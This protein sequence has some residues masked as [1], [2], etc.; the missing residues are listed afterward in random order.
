MNQKKILIISEYFYPEEFKINELVWAWKEKGYHVDVI[1]T[2]PTYPQGEVFRTYTNRWFQ[3]ES[4]KGITIYRV[5][6]V[7]GYKQNLFKKILK[8]ISFMLLGSLVS[9][10][11]GKKYDYVF[12]YD[13]GALTGMI[14][15]I[16]LK[17]FYNIPVTLWI[18]DIWPDSV[19]AYGFKK[20]TPLNFILNSFVKFVY[21]YT[22]NFAVS[23]Q[24][25]KQ[26]IVP[27]LDS[28]KPILYAP[29]WTDPLNNSTEDFIFTDDNKIHFTFAG[30]VGKVQ[31]LENI[32]LAFATLE[33]IFI[34]KAQ[35]NII[36][37]GS[38]LT[39]LKELVRKNNIKSV[40]FHGKKPRNEISKYL[41]ASHFL[42]VSLNDDP[43]FSLTVPSKV[44]TYIAVKKPIIGIINGETASLVTKYELGYIAHPNNLQEI[45]SILVKALTTQHITIDQFTKNCELLTNTLF[46]KNT[47]INSLL[48]LTLTRTD[49]LSLE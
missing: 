7:T 30:N 46:E 28:S 5:K 35:F 13:V 26:R 37:D 32:I 42:I 16:L 15:A 47:I 45:T 41:S 19:Y 31:N 22:S 9:L 21:K 34:S 27:Y 14:P 43:I 33:R 49:E 23:A 18:Q 12:G 39:S 20:S 11:I 38:H 2:L 36:G 24:G 10:K 4:I 3:K 1:T 48:K 6:A 25:F 40:V 44:Q 8:Y 29:N 17:K